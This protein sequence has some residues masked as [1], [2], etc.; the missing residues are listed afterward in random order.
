MEN[1]KGILFSSNQPPP[2]RLLIFSAIQHA[3]LLISL[4][5]AL[6]VTVSR[7][8]GLST[9]ESSTF[10]SATLFALG[11]AAVLQSLNGRLLGGGYQSFA[12]SDSAAISTCVAAAQTGGLP[13]VFGMTVFSGAIHFA[14][15]FFAAR[16]KKIFTSDV[17]GTMIFILGISLVPT[18]MK[19]FLSNGTYTKTGQVPGASFAVAVI[20]LLFMLICSVYWKRMKLYAVLLGIVF[21]YILSLATG[22]MKT[23][24]FFSLNTI[25]IAALPV[26]GRIRIAFNWKLVVPFLVITVA[27]L[28]DN[29]GDFTAAQAANN[30]PK[31]GTDWDAIEKGIRSC[32]LGLMIAGLIGGSIHS[33]S[34]SSTGIAKATGV[35]SRIV[36][37][38]S[39]GIL[40]LLSFF[41]RFVGI[42]SIIPE[43]VLGAVLMFATCYIMASGFGMLAECELDDRRIFLIFVSIVLAT[44]TLIPGLYAFLPETVNAIIVTPV[45]FGAIALVFMKLFISFGRK[46][47]FHFVYVAGQDDIY[48]L[49]EHLSEICRYHGLSKKISQKLK[50]GTDALCEAMTDNNPHARVEFDARYSESSLDLKMTASGIKGVDEDEGGEPTTLSVTLLMLHN[51]FG[52]VAASAG[53]EGYEI[54]IHTDADSE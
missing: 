30:G 7:A 16:L 48:G 11:I 27:G 47:H 8:I 36:A 6:P 40:I 34:T 51:M 54:R 12:A 41:P 53:P 28:I 50:V 13:L 5:I 44:S 26:P 24:A 18:T 2:M 33:T 42:L 10:L 25:P 32:G 29:I 37:Y 22:V 1:A 17:T 46:K 3:L 19:N 4:G 43:P 39:G 49:N 20:T 35:T 9:V 45:V 31:S 21:G 38:A 23:E 14:V 15:S 52:N